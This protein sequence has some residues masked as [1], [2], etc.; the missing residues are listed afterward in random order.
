MVYNHLYEVWV[1]RAKLRIKSKRVCVDR[2]VR[3]FNGN[4]YFAKAIR[5][6]TVTGKRRKPKKGCETKASLRAKA[7]LDQLFDIAEADDLQPV[8]SLAF[9]H[10]MR[11]ERNVSL[12]LSAAPSERRPEE[13]ERQMQIY[14]E[15]VEEEAA[16][17][18]DSFK[19]G[20]EEM[21]DE[22]REEEEEEY[23]IDAEEEKCP[24]DFILPK[25]PIPTAKEGK[26]EDITYR[27]YNDDS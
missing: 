24:I 1:D 27:Y 14:M 15:L 3:N 16:E 11:G 23:Q 21:S 22:E 18:Q 7:K 2:I 6:Q 4:G 8:E 12:P 17:A 5:K 13:R 10:E 19:V 25:E 20:W 9:L 26:V